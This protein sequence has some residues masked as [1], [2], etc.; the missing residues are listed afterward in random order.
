MN[1]HFSRQCK[2]MVKVIMAGLGR[3]FGGKL[4]LT[5]IL[6]PKILFDQ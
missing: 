4:I 5:V 1:A 3:G 2:A 6:E